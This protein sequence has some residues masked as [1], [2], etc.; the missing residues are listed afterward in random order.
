MEAEEKA[1]L[2]I[3][4]FSNG[5]KDGVQHYRRSDGRLLTN[6]E[7]ILIALRDEGEVS[8]IFPGTSSGF[9]YS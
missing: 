7:D 2:L 4:T 8:I 1:E 3:K 6:V 9:S 5:L